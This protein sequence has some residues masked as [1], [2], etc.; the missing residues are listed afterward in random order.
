MFCDGGPAVCDHQRRKPRD[1]ARC[2]AESR[3]VSLPAAKSAAVESCRF[4]TH[5]HE[6]WPLGDSLL[7]GGASANR[8][9]ARTRPCRANSSKIV[10]L[11]SPVR[12]R[13]G[14]QGDE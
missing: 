6:P 2:A 12:S 10:R 5:H 13:P 11:P 8:V 9:L 4:V 1:G 3:F 14:K 7:R